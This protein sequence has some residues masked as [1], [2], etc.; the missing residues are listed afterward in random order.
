MF[1]LVTILHEI[2]QI[3]IPLNQKIPRQVSIIAEAFNTMHPLLG[4]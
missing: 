2:D 4:E 1:T 3:K